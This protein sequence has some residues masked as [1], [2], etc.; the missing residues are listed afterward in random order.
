MS[1]PPSAQR[2]ADEQRFSHTRY[3]TLPAGGPRG[4][5]SALYPGVSQTWYTADKSSTLPGLLALHKGVADESR[6]VLLALVA[7]L[8][9]TALPVLSCIV[10]LNDANY[11]Y[12]IGHTAPWAVILAVLGVALVLFL[13]VFILFQVGKENAKTEDTAYL[14]AVT[15]TSLLG[16]VLVISAMPLSNDI[17]MTA[18]SLQN[19]CAGSVAKAQQLVYFQNVVQNIRAQPAC[20]ANIS[21][22]Q[23]QGWAE[24]PETNY[25]RY[26]EEEL[27]CGPLCAGAVQPPPLRLTELGATSAKRFRRTAAAAGATEQHLVAAAQ[28][29][30]SGQPLTTALFSQGPPVVSDLTCFDIAAMRLEVYADRFVDHIFWEG[31]G[32]LFASV[33]MSFFRSLMWCIGEGKA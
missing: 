2:L 29:G 1:L 5:P 6:I 12:W 11:I 17:H 30:R 31:V 3:V 4:T 19:G 28:G 32:L 18:A 20:M 10:L 26:L 7:F 33:L 22:M 8:G 23:C 25:L 24:T 15:F 14:V 13:T 16:L 21:V 9:M 27:K